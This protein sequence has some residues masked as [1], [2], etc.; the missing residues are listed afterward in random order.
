MILN[1]ELH[2]FLAVLFSGTIRA[3]ILEVH[4]RP[5]VSS[6]CLTARDHKVIENFRQHPSHV[7]NSETSVFSKFVLIQVRRENAIV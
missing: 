2:L 1:Q 7:Y 3:V 5:S 4:I 6:A